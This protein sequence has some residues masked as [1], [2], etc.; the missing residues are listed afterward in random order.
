MHENC[1]VE[2]LHK[3]AAWEERQNMSVALLAVEGLGC[4]TCANRV[5]N[6]LLA[7]YGVTAAQVSHVAANAKILYNPDLTTTEA[8][9][10][11]VVQAGNDGRHN[12]RAQ[13][14]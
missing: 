5:Q 3:E 11:A 1:H 8:L 7:L 6:S 10:D 14:I 12:Y 9:L 2:P 13:F 4:P